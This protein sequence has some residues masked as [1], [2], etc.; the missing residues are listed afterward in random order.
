MYGM[1][2]VQAEFRVNMEGCFLCPQLVNLYG[3]VINQLKTRVFE[4]IVYEKLEHQL[5]GNETPG[6]RA[7][8]RPE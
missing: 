8:I 7:P 3:I 1:S 2:S 5:E 4:A 6:T